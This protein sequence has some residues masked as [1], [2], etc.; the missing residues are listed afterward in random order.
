MSSQASCVRYSQATLPRH[1][2]SLIAQVNHNRP[3]PKLDHVRCIQ[4][5]QQ[6]PS[7]SFAPSAVRHRQTRK[8]TTCSL[9]SLLPACSPSLI[10]ISIVLLSNRRLRLI[11]QIQE[12]AH[13]RF[14]KRPYL[15]FFPAL[16][17]FI[18]AAPSAGPSSQ[19]LFRTAERFLYFDSPYQIAL[20]VW[21]HF[22]WAANRKPEKLMAFPNLQAF[23]VQLFARGFYL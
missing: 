1:S 13:H 2:A 15:R 12:L 17:P 8:S 23:S 3:L 10:M 22:L 11:A 21:P 18:I 5:E 19:P 6:A 4:L 9:F 7:P 20:C 14:C 16:I